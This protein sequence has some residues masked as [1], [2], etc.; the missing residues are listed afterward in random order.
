MADA[1]AKT[2]VATTGDRH[3]SP[4]LLIWLAFIRLKPVKG[5]ASQMRAPS[6][7]PATPD[8][9]PFNLL[10][11]TLMADY[12][13]NTFVQFLLNL[14]PDDRD[15]VRDAVTAYRIGTYKGFTSFPKIDRAGRVAA[16]KLMKFN[17]QTG[18]RLKTDYAVSSLPSELK[19][20]GELKPD[21]ETD[22]DVFFG[23]HL[24]PKFPDLPVAI[25]ESEKTAAIAH[26][27]KGVFPDFVWLAT[28][29]KQWL[30]VDRLRRLGNERIILYPDA[31]GF[32]LWQKIAAAARA[33]GLDVRVTALIENQA[34]AQEKAEQVDIADYLISAQCQVN[35]V[36]SFVD[37][38]NALAETVMTD[39]ALYAQFN[40]ILDE[41]KAILMLD[42]GLSEF[43]AENQISDV[44]YVRSVVLSVG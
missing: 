43:E 18:K 30:N 12:E 2:V 4:L 22:K 19:R 11:R 38:Y 33:Q 10:K 9:I 36:N 23:E 28:G 26:L 15:A 13:Q 17:P 40:S 3:R 6:V 20:V 8:Y 27:C 5:F 29:S 32:D 31:D 1:T 41:R 42:G 21:F 39:G 35:Q 34:N 25:V 14:F 7:Q 24:L 16:A 37:D 44:E